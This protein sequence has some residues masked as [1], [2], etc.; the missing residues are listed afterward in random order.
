M[1]GNK[2]K[3]IEITK[4]KEERKKSIKK[5]LLLNEKIKL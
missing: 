2:Q 3:E 1:I 5:K 4:E